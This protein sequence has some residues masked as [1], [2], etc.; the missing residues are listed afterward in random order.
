MIT[1]ERQYRIVRNKAQRFAQA[2]E[3][4]AATAQERPGVHPRLA[5]AELEG[6]ESQLA[7]LRDELDD[8]ERLK[9][10]DLSVI[11][12]TSLDGLA[13]GLIKARIAARLSQRALAQRLKLKEQQI[14]RYE[15][16][17]YASAN[18]RRMCQ[19]AH[20]LGVRIENDILLPVVPTSF[21]GLVAKVGQ[22]GLSREFVVERLLS[23]ADAAVAEGE[24][25]QERNDERLTANAAATLERVFGW[26]RENILGAQ[27]L[28][29]AW[30]ATATG[31]FKMPKGRQ[32][33]TAGLFAAY[34]NHLAVVATRGMGDCP[35]E[36]IPSDAREMRKKILACG[37]GQDDLRN[38]LHAVW[39]LGVVVLP[40]KGKGTFHGACWRTQGR[41]AIVLKQ[42]SKHE[43]R[44]TFDL[45]H[46]LYHAAQ[47]PEQTTFEVVEE[48]ATSSE[49]RESPEEVAASKYAGDVL[50]KG[51]AEAL[52]REC[53]SL[54]H[55][56]IVGLKR[57]VHRV[58]RAHDVSTDALANYM[59]F[60]LSCKGINW[61]GAAANLQRR[62]DP[63]KIA[64][65]VFVERHPHRIDDEID[66]A[67]L[68]RALHRG[69]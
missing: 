67:L 10:A 36:T 62:S 50:L 69:H 24:V 34:A 38:A 19:V 30:T 65:D 23:T 55:G 44:W 35:T 48:A 8:Y 63:W 29:D 11:S 60:A 68:D 7:E 31:R 20:A 33:R 47:Q 18:Y 46:E 2:I 6:M 4:F 27:A 40:L 41:N 22:V 5:Q 12:V 25:A 57:A 37:Q 52:A 28:S 53:E 49:R 16:E 17:R 61:W 3:E 39:D 66:R 1:N 14:Q 64:R 56:K 9:S 42:T 59:A 21:E 43:A 51:N 45:L 58:A 32:E 15:A 54:A 13:D 26:T